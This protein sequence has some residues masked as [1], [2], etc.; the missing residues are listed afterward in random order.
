MDR[1]QSIL[2]AALKSFSLFGYK[3]TTMDQVA[4][5]ANVGKGTIYTFYSNKEELFSEIVAGILKEMQEVADRSI[6]P[7][8]SFFENA[9]R[10]LISLLDF[11]NEHQLTVKLIQEEKELGTKIVNQELNR[12]E[13]MIIT[14]IKERMEKAIEKGEIR[15]CDPEVTAFLMLKLYVALVVDWEEHHTPLSKEEIANLFELYFIKGLST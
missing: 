1:K 13:Q 3:A 9:H 10:A 2:E 4:K 8:Q 11:R 5:L 15:E 14:F 7:E 12:L 6:N